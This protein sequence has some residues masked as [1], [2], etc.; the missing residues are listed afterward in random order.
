MVCYLEDEVTRLHAQ[1]N[2]T[3]IQLHA[4]Y[5]KNSL[6]QLNELTNRKAKKVIH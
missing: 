6:N 2:L 4:H 1:K 3:E 5:S